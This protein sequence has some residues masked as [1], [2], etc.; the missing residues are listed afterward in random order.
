[1]EGLAGL[2]EHAGIQASVLSRLAVSLLPCTA[3]RLSGCMAANGS[4]VTEGGRSMAY[5]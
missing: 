3:L 4:G 5:N 1:M 2:E